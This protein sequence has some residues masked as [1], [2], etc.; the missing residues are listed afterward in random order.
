MRQDPASSSWVR[1]GKWER[2]KDGKGGRKNEKNGRWEK[3]RG[4]EM[5]RRKKGRRKGKKR[6]GEE[7]PEKNKL[8]TLIKAKTTNAINIRDDY[9][10]SYKT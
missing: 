5:G 6:K 7:N 2:W 4:K 9:T 10:V 1:G 3:K 8:C